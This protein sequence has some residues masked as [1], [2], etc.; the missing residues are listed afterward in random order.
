MSHWQIVEAEIDVDHIKARIEALQAKLVE[1]E[2]VLSDL[3]ARH[4]DVTLWTIDDLMLSIRSHNCLTEFAKPRNG[5]SAWGYPASCVPPT[6]AIATVG[7][8]LKWRASELLKLK[9]FGRKSLQ[10]VTAVL[11]SHEL[12][13]RQEAPING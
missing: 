12:T 4:A 1:A 9:A 10:E 11:A 6:P 13:L 7:D 8:L 2:R 5:Y 3:R